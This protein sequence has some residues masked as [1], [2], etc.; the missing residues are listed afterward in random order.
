[1]NLGQSTFHR[2]GAGIASAVFLV[3]AV[4]EFALDLHVCTFLQSARKLCELAPNRTAVPF[5]PTVIA[6]TRF[7][8]RV[9]VA[10]LSAEPECR[11]LSF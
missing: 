1:M 2:R 7:F 10:M 8:P 3:L 5:G 4:T 11:S 6:S 9:L